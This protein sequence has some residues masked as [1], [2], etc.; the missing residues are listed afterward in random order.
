MHYALARTAHLA[1]GQ[2]VALRF[3]IGTYLTGTSL[4]L[5]RRSFDRRRV[6]RYDSGTTAAIAR[7]PL[8]PRAHFKHVCPCTARYLLRSWWW[9]QEYASQVHTCAE[10]QTK[11]EQAQRA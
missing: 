10:S 11:T 3:F 6:S 7:C 9:E 5:F 8:S 2:V 4:D 1:N